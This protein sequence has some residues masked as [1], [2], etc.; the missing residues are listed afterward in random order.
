MRTI[1]EWGKVKTNLLSKILT[2]RIMLDLE[3]L[4]F[5]SWL[6]QEPITDTFIWGD[7]A[8]GKTIL[9]A[10]MLEKELKDIYL[11][12]GPNHH[13]DTCR[14]INLSNWF[15]DTKSEMFRIKDFTS[16]VEHHGED[17]TQGTYYR[18]CRLLVID[19]IGLTKPTDW[20]VNQLYL[21]INYRYEYLKKTI[22]TSNLSLSDLS[23]L[24]GDDRITSR[25]ERHYTIV[26]KNPYRQ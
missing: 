5:P 1:D 21:L 15:E 17:L 9:A 8:T 10:Q 22:I 20:I 14:F 23:T 26:K 4:P 6:E 18:D 3:K 16:P 11:E 19:D 2:P 12:G 25:I 13:T 7:T 24:L